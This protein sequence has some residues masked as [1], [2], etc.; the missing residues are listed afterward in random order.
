MNNAFLF[1]P[2]HL[3]KPPQVR[4][5][6]LHLVVHLGHLDNTTTHHTRGK[7]REGQKDTR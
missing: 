6:R 3:C 1:R 7:G 2:S 5:A 4:Q